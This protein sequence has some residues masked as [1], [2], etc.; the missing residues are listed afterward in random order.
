MI[1]KPDTFKPPKQDAAP[2]QRVEKPATVLVIGI[3]NDLRRDDGAGL[4][5]I[6]LLGDQLPDTMLRPHNG[7]ATGL[8]QTWEGSDTVILVD[9]THSGAQAGEIHRYD[10]G[11]SPLP[12]ALFRGSSHQLGLAEAVEMAR[13][14][15]RLPARLVVYGI[16]G[17]TFDYGKGL[18]PEVA[19]AVH[20][21]A[22]AILDELCSY[23][24]TQYSK[25]DT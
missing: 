20:K 21:A 22:W 25:T 6:Q 13:A 7:E 19:A 17:K 1:L 3:G 16:E 18:S 9:A 8:M 14:L 24:A 4:A 11:E 23:R 2:T 15:G 10:L 5:V 12:R